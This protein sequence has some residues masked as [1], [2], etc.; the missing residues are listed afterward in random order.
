MEAQTEGYTTIGRLLYK[1]PDVRALLGGISRD[2]FFK[3]L[4]Q[5]KLKS[6]HIG[7]SLYIAEQDLTE[8][9]ESLRN[10]DSTDDSDGAK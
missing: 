1:E 10:G 3:I 2:T 5:G 6:V 9:V 8:F 4:K 7:R